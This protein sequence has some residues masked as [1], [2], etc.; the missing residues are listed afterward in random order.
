MEAASVSECRELR[1]PTVTPRMRATCVVKARNSANRLRQ[2]NGLT[3]ADD[4]SWLRSAIQWL[5][6]NFLYAVHTAFQ[7]AMEVV[8]LIIA[9]FGPLAVGLSLLPGN[10][11]P[12][13]TWVGGFASIFLMKL[14]LNLIS[15]IAAYA[16]SQQGGGIANSLVLPI[17][18]GLLSPILSVM[19]G[20]QGGSTFFNA[21]ST[22][23]VYMGYRKAAGAAKGG[24][25]ALGKGGKAIGRGIGKGISRLRRR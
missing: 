21:L 20:L 2:Q 17:F 4:D 7:W 16:V 19:V 14:T 9:L 23:S 25:K 8:L 1:G 24:G 5:V 18:L 3:S 15:G 11:K 10:S 22:A 6:R 13:F 12:L